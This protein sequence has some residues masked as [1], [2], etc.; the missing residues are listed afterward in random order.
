MTSFICRFSKF[1][2]RY[3]RRYTNHR[4]PKLQ[5]SQLP[6]N[7]LVKNSDEKSTITKLQ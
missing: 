2:D 4:F 7:L 6:I 1:A 5:K 3:V